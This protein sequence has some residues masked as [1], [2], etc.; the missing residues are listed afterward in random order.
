MIGSLSLSLFLLSPA[1]ALCQGFPEYT[2]G[3]EHTRE[4]VLGLSV[5][6]HPRDQAWAAHLIGNYGL[7]E[8]DAVLLD[9]LS[10]GSG[11]HDGE[12]G[13]VDMAVLDS[14]IQLGR[15][16]PAEFLLPL[17]TRFPDQVV[18]L[19]ARRPEENREV[20]H[21]LLDEPARDTRWLALNNL[22]AETKAPGLAARLLRELEVQ[23]SVTVSDEGTLGVTDV[24]GGGLAIGCGVPS[25]PPLGF[26]PW[27]RYRLLDRPLR[28]AVVVAPGPRPIYFE[29]RLPADAGG[30]SAR[31]GDRNQYR[32]EYLASLLEVPVQALGFAARR[33]FTLKW[34]GTGAFLTEVEEIRRQ[35]E[36]SF[37]NLVGRLLE[38]GLLTAQE[39]WPLRLRLRLTVHDVRNHRSIPLPAISWASP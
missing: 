35:L 23:A 20:F 18:I 29:R 5:S 7:E 1:T 3:L 30:S 17:Y 19:L 36:S 9:L 12:W 38:A 21:G 25:R 26:P 37:E 34:G 22:L 31:T 39:A 28:G 6:P 15:S 10:P 2:L 4:A 8:E 24:P 16:P 27:V 32:V 33:S 11:R 13:W 14:L